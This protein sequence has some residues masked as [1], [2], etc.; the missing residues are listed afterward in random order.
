VQPLSRAVGCKRCG[1]TGYRGRLPLVEVAVIT[2]TLA[3]M[4]AAGATAHALQRAAVAQGMVSMREGAAGRVLRGET[5][6]QEIER[7]VGDIIAE[8]PQGRPNGVASIL[9]VNADPTWRRM[10]RA[11]LESS[12]VRVV[13]AVDAQAAQIMSSGEQ[14]TL[15]LTDMMMPSPVGEVAKVAADPKATPVW[16]PVVRPLPAPIG[17]TQH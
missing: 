13:E 15:V 8:Q 14:F 1:S 12:E 17:R 3:D 11:L 7:V 9:L 10:A 6:L 2:P 16:T 5:T 4:I